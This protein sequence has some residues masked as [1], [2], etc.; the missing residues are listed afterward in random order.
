M[1]LPL[2]VRSNAFL[3]PSSFLWFWILGG[4]FVLFFFIVTLTSFCL[5]NIPPR[6]VLLT[7]SFLVGPCALLGDVEVSF[8]AYM[9]H[10]VCVEASF[11]VLGFNSFEERSIGVPIALASAPTRPSP[12]TAIASSTA[13]NLWDPSPAAPASLVLVA[14][15]NYKDFSN[16]GCHIG[17]SANPITNLVV[18]DFG[19]VQ[20]DGHVILNLNPINQSLKYCLLCEL[21]LILCYC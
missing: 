1:T 13:F 4:V 12:S 16:L 6:V 7:V 15:C 5:L 2:L 19:I 9:L 18:L 11:E 10:I 14:F 21:V 20:R 17:H 3:P 8:S